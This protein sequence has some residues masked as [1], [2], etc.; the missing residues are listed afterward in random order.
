MLRQFVLLLALVSNIIIPASSLPN[1]Q[2]QPNPQFPN[3]QFPNP[4][5]PNPQ[6]PNPQLPNPQGPNPRGR[7][8]GVRLQ[9]ATAQIDVTFI[10]D[11]V[12]N[13]PRVRIEQRSIPAGDT[14]RWHLHVREVTDPLCVSTEVAHWDPTRRNVNGVYNPV[15][16]RLDS[17]EVGDMSGKWG[18][19][20]A[21]LNGQ[22]VDYVDPTLLDTGGLGWGA[23]SIQL[24]SVGRNNAKVACANLVE[25]RR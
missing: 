17:Y 11:F 18:P 25:L 22:I 10:Y 24:H 16:G 2:L 14:F 23:R 9:N 3:P 15:M 7:R 4:Q 8:Y 21:N 20:N 5:L 19:L 6:L 12:A 1:P 13:P